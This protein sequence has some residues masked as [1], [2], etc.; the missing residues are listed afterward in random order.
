MRCPSMAACAARRVPCRS[1]NFGRTVASVRASRFTTQA[2]IVG[3]RAAAIALRCLRVAALACGRREFLAPS[4][5]LLRPR[6]VEQIEVVVDGHRCDLVGW[7]SH[8]PIFADEQMSIEPMGPGR[9]PAGTRCASTGRLSA[10]LPGRERGT[11]PTT[12]VCGGASM[13]TPVRAH[14]SVTE[15]R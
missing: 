3:R 5:E 13:P 7:A 14:A 4:R 8:L 6:A 15:N 10:G 2:A 1:A 9:T 12:R 11:R